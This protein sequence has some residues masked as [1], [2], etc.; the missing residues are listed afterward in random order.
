MGVRNL[1]GTT[2]FRSLGNAPVAQIAQVNEEKMTIFNFF[3]E[4][5]HYLM[6]MIVLYSIFLKAIKEEA[7]NY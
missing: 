7:A 4:D 5:V 2:P 3:I 6:L 1:F